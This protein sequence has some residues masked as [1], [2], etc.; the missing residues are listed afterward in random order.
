[1]ERDAKDQGHDEEEDEEELEAVARTIEDSEPMKKIITL[2]MKA[3][4]RLTRTTRFE[5]LP[6]SFFRGGYFCFGCLV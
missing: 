3:P 6:F 4:T 1:M 5:E 2:L